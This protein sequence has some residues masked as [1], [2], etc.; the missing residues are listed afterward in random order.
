VVLFVAYNNIM[1]H[2]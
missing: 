1:L 2:Y